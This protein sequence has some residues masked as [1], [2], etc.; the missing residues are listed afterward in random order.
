MLAIVPHQKEGGKFLD[1]LE[2]E[3][4]E[5]GYFHEV[6]LKCLVEV[7]VRCSPPR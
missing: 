1:L 4:L 5:L 6:D 2:V 7:S 3:L